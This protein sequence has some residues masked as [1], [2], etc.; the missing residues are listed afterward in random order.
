MTEPK[1]K[2]EPLEGILEEEGQQI[3]NHI[4]DVELDPM[5]VNLLF[6]HGNPHNLSQAQRAVIVEELRRS[7]KTYLTKKVAKRKK[8]DAKAKTTI[9]KSGFDLE[10]LNL[11]IDDIL[12]GK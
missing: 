9:T 12:K 2:P 7:R 4:Q 1:P 3:L 6:T 11:D 10:D 8:A 5:E